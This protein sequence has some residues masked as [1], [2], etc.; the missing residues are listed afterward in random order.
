MLIPTYGQVEK[1]GIIRS[2]KIIYESGR[3]LIPSLS[4]Q[5]KPTKFAKLIM[6]TDL[7]LTSS[8]TKVYL[9]LSAPGCHLGRV[10]INVYG[11]RSYGQQ[12][13]MLTLGTDGKSFKNSKFYNKDNEHILMQTYITETGSHSYD[14]VLS[15]LNPGE[16]ESWVR[17]KLSSYWLGTAN[18]VIMTKA[19]NQKHGS[20]F[21]H[22]IEGMDIIDRI[23]SDEFRITDIF[24]SD[25]GIILNY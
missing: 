2:S 11:D 22:V 10:V 17:G 13:I 25:C 16:E 24:I 4:A 3:M 1:N 21:G 5:V 12:F 8:S 18:F 14:A 19:K 9:E 15:P 7:H 23:S 20:H 6:D